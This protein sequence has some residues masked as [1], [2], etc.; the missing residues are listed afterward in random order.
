VAAAQAQQPPALTTKGSGAAT[1]ADY[2]TGP[3]PK[4]LT[5]PSQTPSGINSIRAI[6]SFD[7]EVPVVKNWRN[8]LLRSDVRVADRSFAGEIV[9]DRAGSYENFV[10]EDDGGK[11]TLQSA[12]LDVQ[13]GAEEIYRQMISRDPGLKNG[14]VTFVMTGSHVPVGDTAKF[15]YAQTQLWQSLLGSHQIWMSATVTVSPGDAGNPRFS[16]RMSLHA[17]SFFAEESGTSDE[18]ASIYA[19][20]ERDV[21]W[22]GG[23]AENAVSK[24]VNNRSRI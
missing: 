1:V 14:T 23:Q 17:E 9:T 12:T 24:Q 13:A 18:Q 2:H 22:F 5:Q 6:P 3:P 11:T 8:N 21:S 19:T 10:R 7:T 15:P 4:S 20:L 16:M